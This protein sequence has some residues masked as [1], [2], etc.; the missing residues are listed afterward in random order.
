MAHYAKVLDGKVV[1]IIVAEPEF[2]DSFIDSEPGEWIKCSFNM[3]GGK[4]I[5]PDT[6]EPVADQSIVTGDAARERKNY[7][8]V[9]WNYDPIEDVFFDNKS[10]SSWILNTTTY[11]HEAP[12]A[13]PDDGNKYTWDE[14]AHQAD[15]TAGWVLVSGDE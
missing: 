3:H 10:Y 14:D 9:G 8:G 5:D 4:Y 6:R 11:L 13:Y 12:I 7:P 1:N 2:F 15:N